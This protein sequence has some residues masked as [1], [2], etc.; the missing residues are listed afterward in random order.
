MASRRHRW[1]LLLAKQTTQCP[2]E[3]AHLG[4][5]GVRVQA[6]GLPRLK[7]RPQAASPMGHVGVG[8]VLDVA[9]AE[10]RGGGEEGEG[11]EASTAGD[12]VYSCATGCSAAMSPPSPTPHSTNTTATPKLPL[13]HSHVKGVGGLPARALCCKGT[14]EQNALLGALSQEAAAGAKPGGMCAAACAHSLPA[15]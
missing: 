2:G 13:H 8:S 6:V 7:Q 15:A 14:S 10:R 4:L 3:Q 11:Q 12:A 5:Q 1:H 9:A